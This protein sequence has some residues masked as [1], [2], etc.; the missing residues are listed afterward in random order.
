MRTAR[1]AQGPTA[2]Q[3]EQW[4]RV[5]AIS[6]ERSAKP[7]YERWNE[8]VDRSGDCWIWVG[9]RTIASGYGV[10]GGKDIGTVLAHRFSYE[11]H[12]GKIPEGLFVCHRCDNPPCVNPAHLFVGTHADNMRDMVAKGR[13][14]RPAVPVP[15]SALE[16]EG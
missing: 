5:I 13:S 14:R 6:K 11:H 3:L 15:L 12:I 10:L 16:R 2:A 4:D 1:L 9:A 7:L 8:K